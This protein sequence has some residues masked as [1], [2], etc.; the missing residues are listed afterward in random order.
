MNAVPG[1]AQQSSEESG[2]CP[3]CEK[4]TEATKTEFLQKLTKATKVWGSRTF[5]GT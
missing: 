2:I 5:P 3:K 1:S 4:I